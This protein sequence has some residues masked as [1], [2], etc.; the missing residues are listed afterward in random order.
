MPIDYSLYPRN[1][2]TEIVPAIRKRSGNRCEECGIPNDIY[3]TRHKD[4]SWS[5]PN[6]QELMAI[7]S[8]VTKFFTLLQSFKAQG[9][10]KIILH[11]RHKDHDKTNNSWHPEDKDDPSNNLFDW[12]QKCAQRNERPIVDNKRRLGRKWKQ[13]QMSLN[14]FENET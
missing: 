6:G 7:K 8:K 2:K 1:W 4:G 9:F 11:V 13:G 12:C 14:L 5:E 3:I 10:F